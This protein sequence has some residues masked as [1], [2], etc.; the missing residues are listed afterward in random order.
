MLLATTYESSTDIIINQEPSRFS[1]SL[2]ASSAP[3]EL[4]YKKKT[5]KKKDK[6]RKP[7]L[8]ASRNV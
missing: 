1:K 3:S 2:L 5:S 6:I 8:A 7:T 4:L